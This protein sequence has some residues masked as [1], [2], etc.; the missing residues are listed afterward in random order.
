M[1]VD[2]RL[3]EPPVARPENQPASVLHPPPANYLAPPF[4][5]DF[6]CEFALVPPF[7]VLNVSS[8][9]AHGIQSMWA[10]FTL[11]L[12]LALFSQTQVTKA[13]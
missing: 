5:P 2:G 11:R 8:Q 12:A 7:F 9:M 4:E 6:N 1:L 13:L 10:Q 3:E